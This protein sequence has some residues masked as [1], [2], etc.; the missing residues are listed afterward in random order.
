MS[1]PVTPELWSV[2]VL[3]QAKNSNDLTK[4]YNSFEVA[5]GKKNN[6]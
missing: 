5:K 1:C 6:N 3:P 2:G 4:N